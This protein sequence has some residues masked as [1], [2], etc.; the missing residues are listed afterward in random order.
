MHKLFQSIYLLKGENES[1]I[2]PYCNCLYLGGSVKTVIDTGATKSA[3]EKVPH[4][5]IDLVIN[6]HYHADHI[7]NNSLFPNAKFIAHHLDTLAI[8]KEEFFI[9]YSGYNQLPLEKKNAIVN[10]LQYKSHKI[11][12]TIND[13]DLLLSDKLLI[14]VI[15]TPGH[16]A[17]H[18]CFYFP[19]YDF[20]YSG[21]IDLTSFGPWYGDTK[22]NLNDYI[23]SINKLMMIKPKMIV[24][25]HDIIV[26]GKDVIKS[27]KNYL[28]IIY[29]RE[30]RVLDFLSAPMPVTALFNQR[31]I[32]GNYPE[33]AWPFKFWEQQMI[34][35]HLHK[36]EDEGA[37]VKTDNSFYQK[38][39]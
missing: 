16:T 14:K 26:Q 11:D 27:L 25:G 34:I 9:N 37:I 29:K 19:E 32:Y 30:Q 23:K 8:E 7:R 20:I 35:K 28:D 6:S 24:T 18:C 13:E 12:D 22:A 15:H 21:D 5:H 2:P 17:G 4:N 38:V 31:L 10:V 33:P 36:L 39:C 1:K 3:F